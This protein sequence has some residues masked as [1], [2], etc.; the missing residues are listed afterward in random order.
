MRIRTVLLAML[1]ALTVACSGG[2]STSTNSVVS[3]AYEFVV[4]SNVTG[5][6]TLVEANL[7]ANGNQSSATGPSR[8]QILSLEKKNWYVNGVCPGGTPG[9]NS[10]SANVTRSNIALTFDQGGNSLPGQG[11]LAGTTIT[12][13][14]SVTGSTCPDLIG[15][16]NLGFPSGSDSG[17]F[18]GNQVPELAGTFSGT[19]NLTTG[20]H[21]AALALTEGANQTLTVSAQLN[22]PVD[23]GTF[24]LTGS[25]VGNIMFVSG[26]VNGTTLSLFGYFDRAGAYTGIPKSM[27]VFD[28]DTLGEIGVLVS[29]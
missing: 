3:G 11:V 17:G 8:V 1:L 29:Q 21:D 14:Y 6:T 27:L 18:V 19:L 24:P 10:V 22:G 16:V 5:S 2:S 20:T 4:T 23:N 13:N 12:G 9:Q 7:A 15:E 26:P 25:A 28:Y